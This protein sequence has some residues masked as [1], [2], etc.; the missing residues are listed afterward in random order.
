[1]ERKGV[2][3]VNGH[4]LHCID[5]NVSYPA[6]GGN[7]PRPMSQCSSKLSFDDG[8]LRR[9]KDLGHDLFRNARKR[10]FHVDR[11]EKPGSFRHAVNE[12]TRFVLA[13]GSRASLPHLEEAR[14]S[15]AAHPGED[16]AYGILPAADAKELNSLNRLEEENGGLL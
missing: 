15:V 9:A 2:A 10:K 3:N 5:E 8:G 1:M 11:A 7:Q 12:A 6:L 16:D 13:D 14:C 4:F